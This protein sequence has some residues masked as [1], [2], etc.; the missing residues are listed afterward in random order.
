PGGGAAQPMGAGGLKLA[1]Q[2]L[3]SA[4]PP[5]NPE[6]TIPDFAGAPI[7]FWP[8]LPSFVGAAYDIVV[9]Q[10][11]AGQKCI[12]RTLAA[13]VPAPGPLTFGTR[14][15]A[16]AMQGSTLWLSN[17]PATGA[18]SGHTWNPDSVAVR[19]RALPPAEKVL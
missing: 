6:V 5:A 2:K 7:T 17:P 9:T 14:A 1:L 4:E 12:V 11:P 13:A 18:S 3:G 8:D 16:G 15:V 19:C 10:N